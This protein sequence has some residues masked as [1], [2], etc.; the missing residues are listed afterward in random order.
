MHQ[1]RYR[2]AKCK[3]FK[4]AK[5]VC[6][7]SCPAC[8]YRV[9]VCIEKC[10]GRYNSFQRLMMHV[11]YFALDSRRVR[12]IEGCASHLAYMKEVRRRLANIYGE[13][14]VREAEIRAGVDWREK[15]RTRTLN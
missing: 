1:R 13:D 2:C 6:L 12:G 14:V 3:K 7:Y 8:Q 9:A 15:A 10:G 5:E 4:L 11:Q